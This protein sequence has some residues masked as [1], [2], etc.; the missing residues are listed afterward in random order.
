MVWY[1]ILRDDILWY[2]SGDARLVANDDVRLS[3]VLGTSRA[4]PVPALGCKYNVTPICSC[5]CQ[6]VRC[7]PWSST[8]YIELYCS[9]VVCLFVLLQRCIVA[10]VFVVE[11]VN[12]R[13]L[14]K[15]TAVSFA[16][17]IFVFYKCV[18]CRC[19]FLV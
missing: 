8:V 4:P 1:G 16:L 11:F 7:D 14:V 5:F 18:L 3:W 13:R 9:V 10:I 19:V 6:L 12:T 17:Y 15:H 2:G